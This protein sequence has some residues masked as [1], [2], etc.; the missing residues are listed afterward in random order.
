MN[1]G[2]IALLIGL[3]AGSIPAWWLTADHYTGKIAKNEVEHQKRII[4]QQ[5]ES[6]QGLLAYANRIATAG[7]EREKNAIT[8]RNLS[9]ELERLRINFPVCPVPAATGTGADIDGGAG[10]L[11]DA[12][13]ALFAR[14]QGRAGELIERCDTLNIDAIRRNAESQPPQRK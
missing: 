11:S 9:R 2:L 6:R 8:V 1:P 5:E 10:L 3:A 7:G 14:L 4:D 13:D 12:V